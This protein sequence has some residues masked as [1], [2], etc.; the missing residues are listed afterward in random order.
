MKKVFAV[1]NMFLKSG[2]ATPGP[3]LGSALG[4][5]GVNIMNFCKSFNSESLGIKDVEKGSMIPVV[6]TIYTDRSF[7]FV[8]K[9][10]T[11]SYLLIK[12]SK[13]T[14]GSSFPKKNIVG[15]V[16]SDDLM[17]IIKIKKSDLICSDESSMV[18]TIVGT[19]RSMG[20]NV[21]GYL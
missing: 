21:E 6:V 3:K 13:V 2:E 1:V 16:T 15:T 11:V 18:R 14:K 9:K 4:P 8:L 10:P 20:I 12:F 5:K 17:S 7:S 19:A